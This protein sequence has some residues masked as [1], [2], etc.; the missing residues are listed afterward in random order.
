M[1]Y[2]NQRSATS[3]S[4][5][6][7]NLLTPTDR[8]VIRLSGLGQFAPAGRQPALLVIDVT[9][10]FCGDKPEP[11]L[12]SVRRYRNSSGAI[13]WDSVAVIG[14]LVEAARAASV[15]VIYTRAMTSSSGIGP[16]RWAA[17][18][19]RVDEDDGEQHRIVGPL[20]PEPGDIIVDKTKPSGFFGTPLLSF[21]V[22]HGIDSLIVCGC[23]T[24]GC[25]RATVVDAFSNNL[26]VSVVSD[27]CF[28]RIAVSHVVSLFEMN[29]KYGN[30]VD[31]T[32]AIDLI[33]TARPS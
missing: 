17:K 19:R 29:L 27:G 21:M 6:A 33:R 12:E 3:W 15:P 1:A 7:E 5:E 22:D 28:D 25:V 8:E 10:A 9:E 31:S 2:P 30:V 26:P 24:S 4:E 14:R 11:I 32:T 18:N 23:T 16:G 20:R 13:A